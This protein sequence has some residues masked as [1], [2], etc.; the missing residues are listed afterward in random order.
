[1]IA[2]KTY[3][4]VPM[5]AFRKMSPQTAAVL[6]NSSRSMPSACNIPKHGHNKTTLN[7]PTNPKKSDMSNLDSS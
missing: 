5:R 1:M 6:G 3:K 4:K 2:M 7:A